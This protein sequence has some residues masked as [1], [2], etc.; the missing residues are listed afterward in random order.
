MEPKLCCLKVTLVPCLPLRQYCL[1]PDRQLDCNGL[2]FG[3]CIR[4]DRFNPSGRVLFRCGLQS[5]ALPLR[6]HGY[7]LSVLK[8][9]LHRHVFD[10][11]IPAPWGGSALWWGPVGERREAGPA[12]GVLEIADCGGFYRLPIGARGWGGEF[13]GIDCWRR[14]F[15]CRSMPAWRGCQG[16]LNVVDGR[17][18]W[19][20]T[21]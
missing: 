10:S 17:S 20:L 11:S 19:A 14:I 8:W 13:S 15:G 18:A 5:S 6:G 12:A 7:C 2:H 9:A 16:A 21:L 1:M 4:A 3:T